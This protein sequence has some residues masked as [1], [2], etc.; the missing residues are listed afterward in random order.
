MELAVKQ[1]LA[2]SADKLGIEIRRELEGALDR[3]LDVLLAWNRKINL[4]AVRDPAGIVVRHFLDSLSVLPY[5]PQGTEALVDVGSGAGFPGAVLALARPHLRVT[6]VEPNHKKSAFL[7]A[8]KR[9]VPIPNV[10]VATARYEEFSSLRP[11][12]FDVAISRA[13][14]D[15]LDW[16]SR[17]RA[18]VRPQGGLIIA[19]E[20]SERHVLP[21]TCERVEFEV[22]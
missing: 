2:R 7:Q 21:S 1:L 6:L 20:G 18:L 14:W 3:Y 5:L 4:T 22:G 11:M 19:M 15:V 13:T 10:E 8:I 16:L 17:A 12:A 9:D